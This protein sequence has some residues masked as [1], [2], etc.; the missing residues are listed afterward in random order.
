MFPSRPPPSGNQGEALLVMRVQVL[1]VSHLTCVPGHIQV[2]SV[3]TGTHMQ[4]LSSQAAEFAAPHHEKQGIFVL[5]EYV[6]SA[7]FIPVKKRI[8]HALTL[9]TL[10]GAANTKLIIR[11]FIGSTISKEAAT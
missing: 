2:C 9:F 5:R 3:G 6:S 7:P 8:T 11:L 10:V 4:P 1:C